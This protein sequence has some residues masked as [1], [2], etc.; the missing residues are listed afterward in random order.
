MNDY[1][2]FLFVLLAYILF[3]VGLGFYFS[4][5]EQTPTEFWL[6]G[7]SADALSIG[8]L[9]LLHGL[10]L[11]RFWRSPGSTCYSEWAPSGGLSHPIF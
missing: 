4:R 7:K 3:L 2:V 11:V 5:R 10:P 9:Q 1:H 8:F 6:A